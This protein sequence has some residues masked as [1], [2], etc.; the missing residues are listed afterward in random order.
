[1]Y[2]RNKKKNTRIQPH[3]NNNLPPFILTKKPRSLEADIL[4]VLKWT[5][6]PRWASDGCCAT[7][8][9]LLS[10][11]HVLTVAGLRPFS[12]TSSQTLALVDA[13][14]IHQNRGAGRREERGMLGRH[15]L[16]K[17]DFT[18]V[19]TAQCCYVQWSVTVEV[20]YTERSNPIIHACFASCALIFK[21]L[22]IKKQ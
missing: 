1:M 11:L 18:L 12:A 17:E 5:F 14:P 10:H 4:L 15:G 7:T 16:L 6:E 9:G 22:K 3:P 19:M 2:I 21:M 13:F 8:T 20:K